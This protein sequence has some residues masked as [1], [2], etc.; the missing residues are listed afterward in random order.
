MEYDVEADPKPAHA[1]VTSPA[2]TARCRCLVE[3]GK[4]I[5]IGWQG[6]GCVVGQALPPA[7]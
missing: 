1:C 6:R 5:Q 7:N 4:V 2:V 3:D